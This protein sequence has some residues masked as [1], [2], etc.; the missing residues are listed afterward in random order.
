M[1]DQFDLV[2][3]QLYFMGN[4]LDLVVHQLDF[5]GNQFDLVV[6]QFD[7]LVYHLH[8]NCCDVIALG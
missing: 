4:L 5:V 6:H 1:V 8:L 2:V 7:F 3:H